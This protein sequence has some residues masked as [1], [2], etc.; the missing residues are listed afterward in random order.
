MLA[1]EFLEAWHLNKSPISGHREINHIYTPSRRD[2]KKLKKSKDQNI[3][4]PTVNFQIRDQHKTKDQAENNTLTK[5]LLQG[6]S[7]PY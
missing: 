2:N 7:L 5:E 6:K 4:L 3:F 1:S